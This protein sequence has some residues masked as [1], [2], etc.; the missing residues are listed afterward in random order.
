M[1]KQICEWLL[2]DENPEVKLRTLKEY[3]KYDDKH[4]EVIKAKE[5]LINSNVYERII[6]KLHSDKKWDKFDALMVFPWIPK[7]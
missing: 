1:E 3:L 5:N 4:P 6:K 7:L 2:T